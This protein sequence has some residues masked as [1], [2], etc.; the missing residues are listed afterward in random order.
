MH[1]RLGK[2]CESVI[3]AG[4][5]AA[6]IIVP[7]FFNVYSA[8]VFEPD[9]LSLL[10]SIALVMALAWLVKGIE[11]ALLRSEPL[12]A[13][14]PQ[15]TSRPSV[16][17]GLLGTPLVLPT[18][19]LVLAYL[20]STAF[21]LA[22]RISW[23]GSYQRLQGTYTTLSYIVIFFLVLGHLR[24]REQL[25]RLTFV[26][27]LTSL[28]ISVYGIVQHAGMDPLPWGGDVE[29]RVASNMGNSI[30]VA[31]YLILALFL[32]VE[33]LLRAT[34]R[35]LAAGGGMADAVRAGCYLFIIVAQLLCILYTKSRGPWLGLLAGLYIFVL[36]VLIALGRQ[37]KAFRRLWLGWIAVSLV[38]VGFL[39]AINL[40]NTP[41]SGF[42]ALPY[43]G[44]LGQVFEL[45]RGTGRVRTLIWEGVLDLIVPHEPLVYPDDGADRFNALRPVVG[46][47]PE[48]MWVAYNRFYPPDLAHYEARNASPDRSH[49][50]TY[51]A[52][53]IS[54]YFGFAAYIALFT[55]LFYFA[56]RWLGLIRSRRQLWIFLGLWFGTGLLSALG[57]RVADGGWRL[58]GVALPA[59]MILGFV[60]YVT[61]ATLR[62]SKAEGSSSM[63]RSLLVITLLAT[64]VAHFVEIHFGIAIAATRTYF[65]VLAAVLV[66][67]GLEWLP[68]QE[69][70]QSTTEPT[71][72]AS[73]PSSKRGR[74]RRPSRAPTRVPERSARL[75]TLGT[76]LVYSLLVALMLFTLVYDYVHNDQS[77]PGSGAAEIFWNSLTTRLDGNAR[78]KD[79]AVLTVVLGT[80]LVGVMLSLA[81]AGDQRS[82]GGNRAYA[83]LGPAAAS[84]VIVSLGVFLCFGLIQAGRL[85]QALSTP[86]HIANHITVYYVGAF[87]L[88]LLIG[89]AIWWQGPLPFRRWSRSAGASAL[90]GCIGAAL[91]AVFIA[92]V[93]VSLV[94]ADVYYKMGQNFDNAGQWE[95]SIALHSKALEIAPD[96]DYYRLFRGRAELELA[97]QA[98]DPARR[99]ALLE[100][101]LQDLARARELN[102]LNTDHTANLGRLYR[103]WGELS[104]DADERNQKLQQ[105]LRY[106]EQAISL[107]PN[108]AHLYNE[109]GLVY[110]VLGENDKAEEQYGRSLSLDQDYV[111][112]YFILG[113]F[114][115]VQARRQEAVEAYTHAVRCTPRSVEDYCAQG[116]SYSHLG[117]YEEAEEAYRRAVTRDTRSARG[118]SG[119]GYAYA[120][121]GRLPEAIA[122]YERV[123]ELAP[124][125]LYSTRNLALLYQ[126]LGNLEKALQYA[127][128]ARDLSSESER[129]LVDS[130]IEQIEVQLQ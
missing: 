84:S 29:T 106:Y 58:F 100:A 46:Y 24:R 116:D 91:I 79:L 71:H 85:R 18:L 66:V 107:S 92:A 73:G 70:A 56:L 13:G 25:E 102:P 108:S 119:L 121:L 120:Q 125:D 26:I 14:P 86:D 22:P 1:T 87:V 112:T 36:L 15:G 2:W 23:W 32:T 81:A 39:V 27:I 31:A 110:Q 17:G 61:L 113:E 126:E 122:A 105:S 74:R 63:R 34:R 35:M 43:I 77:L 10:R 59:G 12:P 20:V 33:Q 50:E 129:P 68:L 3:E 117:R 53:V 6:L 54:G 51:D 30:F 99:N 93:N 67:V 52:L 55:S 69:G 104:S 9:K 41:L 8:R 88:L 95:T 98:E 48:A 21:S 90:A 47:G 111:Q 7:L 37:S 45:D 19:V 60:V 72:A 42:K 83:W 78:V 5:L 103:A 11:H 75:Q 16:P 97:K 94:K 109:Y 76:V 65:W 124:D 114:Y 128:A 82:V 64:I 123:L 57:F 80:W 62:G 38:G 96:E 118:H 127:Y 44:R 40:P 130:L 28:P 115:R 101:G 4:W 89:T 49:N